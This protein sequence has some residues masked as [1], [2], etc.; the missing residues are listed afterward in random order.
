MAFV[1]LGSSHCLD[2]LSE[3]SHRRITSSTMKRQLQVEVGVGM[4]DDFCLITNRLRPS[5]VRRANLLNGAG[6][7]SQHN[8]SP[9]ILAVILYSSTRLEV[10]IT[11]SRLRHL[12]RACYVQGQRYLTLSS[13][14]PTPASMGRVRNGTVSARSHHGQWKVQHVGSFTAHSGTSGVCL[15]GFVPTQ[16]PCQYLNCA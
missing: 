1:V 9:G 14:P 4:A 12:Y 10:W 3:G 16:C 13:K 5:L 11:A 6:L 8:S 7:E 15:G 2:Y